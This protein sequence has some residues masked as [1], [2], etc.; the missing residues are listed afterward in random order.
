[1]GDQIRVGGI[2]SGLKLRMFL[3]FWVGNGKKFHF[4]QSTQRSRKVG[5]VNREG[6]KGWR[7]FTLRLSHNGIFFHTTAQRSQRCGVSLCG[8]SVTFAAFA[9]DFSQWRKD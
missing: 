5:K 3:V 1:M 9:G 4:P 2:K 7:Q 6:R 8:L